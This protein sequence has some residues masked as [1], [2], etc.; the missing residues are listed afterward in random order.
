MSSAS[1]ADIIEL[2]ERQA[3]HWIESRARSNLFEKAWL[4]RFG[5]LVPPGC[6]I[7]D[8]GCGSGEPI[9]AYLI[10][11]G[12]PVTGVDS[13][14]ALIE[15]CSKRFPEQDWI[16]ADMRAL[17]LQRNFC[18]IIAWDSFFHLAHDDQRR[19]FPL[20]RAHA[21]PGAPLLFTSGPAHGEAIG[22]IGGEPLYHASLGPAEY[23]SLLD[24]N[25]FRVVEHIV[26]DPD[27]GGHTVWLAQLA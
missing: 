18:G 27:C 9:A 15:A 1:A 12:H 19:M 22:E 10:G 8:L 5:A 6:G 26:E 3:S 20:F 21:A 7:L 11:L 13:S 16:I 23:R 25:G 24:S 17:A 2:Y 14:P 4:D